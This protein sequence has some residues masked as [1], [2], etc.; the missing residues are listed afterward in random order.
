MEDYIQLEKVQAELDVDSIS[1]E[2]KELLQETALIIAEASDKTC[3]LNFV[4]THNS[5]RSHLAQIWATYFSVKYKVENIQCYSSGSEAT[6]MFPMIYKT[7]ENQGFLIS[8]QESTETNP[9]ISISFSNEHDAIDCFSKT[10]F[11]PSLPENNMIA[12]MVCSDA[13]EN[14]PFIP[15]A[16]KRIKITYEDPKVSDGTS[17]MEAKYKERSIQIATEMKF[18]MKM[19]K[20]PKK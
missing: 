10:I 17:G 11:D 8:G 6:A 4:C 18:L 3:H 13:D 2:R 16:L 15:G 20:E 14:C 1:V 5:R 7:L 19:V 12:I 9:N